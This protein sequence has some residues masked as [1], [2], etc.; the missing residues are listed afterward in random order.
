MRRR[1]ALSAAMMVLALVI[2]GCGSSGGSSESTA[3]GETVADSGSD[4]AGSDI[5]VAYVSPVA[6]QPGQQQLSLGLERGAAELGWSASVLDSAIS[7]DK[8]VS[9]VETAINRGDAAIASWTIDPNAVAGAYEQAQAKGVPV[10]GI[11]SEG[12]GVTSTVWWDTQLCEPDGP[13]A[14]SA[15][16]IAELRPNAKTIMIVQEAAE[17]TR[18]VFECFAKEAK[19]AGLDVVNMTNNETDDAAG[20]QAVFEPLLTKYPEVEA[21]WSYNDQSALGVSAAL[22]AAGD[23]VASGDASEGVIVTGSN[24]DHDA[25]E[26]VEEGRMTWT[27][28]PDYLATGYAA[29]K[30]M[31][32]ALEGEEPPAVTVEAE[33]FDSQT[34]V[35]YVPPE[36]RDYSIENLPLKE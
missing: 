16:R 9:H 8:Q 21:V 11:N 3:S 29:V 26:A 28:D 4:T 5:S 19:A 6:A 32:E 31:N 7:P 1:Y 13:Q 35:D 10:I 25:I 34:V 36:D 24:G 23:E 30:L 27:W 15:Q 17:S 14:E 12:T 22:L 20:A 2:A 33:L 18:A